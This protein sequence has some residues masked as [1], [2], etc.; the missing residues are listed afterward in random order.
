MKTHLLSVLLLLL[1]LGVSTGCTSVQVC[2]EGD[3][4]MITASNEGLFVLYCIPIC[5]GDPE[6]PNEQ[7]SSWWTNTVKVETNVKLLE[8]KA[9]ECGAHGIKNL[10]SLHDSTSYFWI[11]LQRKTC[12]SSAELV[13]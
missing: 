8:E 12:R 5:S 6:Y 9:A 1:A 13:K 10:V 11:L 4:N 7:V 2:H 3:T